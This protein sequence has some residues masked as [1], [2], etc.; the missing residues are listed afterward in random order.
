MTSTLLD[1]YDRHLMEYDE[2]YERPERA[3]LIKE[4]R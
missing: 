1:Y 4:A 3:A 2:I